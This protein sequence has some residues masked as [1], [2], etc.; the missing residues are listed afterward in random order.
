MRVSSTNKSAE[1]KD[2]VKTDGGFTVQQ[3]MLLAFAFFLGIASVMTIDKIFISNSGHTGALHA[4]V[5]TNQPHNNN[6]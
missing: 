1:I 3:W 6:K 5:V 4:G 2:G